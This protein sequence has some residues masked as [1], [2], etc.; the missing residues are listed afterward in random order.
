M[1]VI[2]FH[3]WVYYV[4]ED[5][6]KLEEHKSGKWMYFFDNIDFA[7]RI[8]QEAVETG[9][10]VEAKHSDDLTGVCC[11]YLNGD[12][13]DPHRK[14]IQFFLKHDLIRKTAKGKLYNIS[15]KYNYQ[16]RAKEYGAQFQ[17]EIKLDRFLN[18]ETGEWKF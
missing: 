18:L 7:S 5:A 11:F 10:V 17:S 13:M 3:N 8:C 2:N 9:V 1:E 15:F 16:T 6:D 14:T 12:N 4:G